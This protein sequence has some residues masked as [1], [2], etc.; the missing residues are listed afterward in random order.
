[1]Q[2]NA[3]CGVIISGGFVELLSNYMLIDPAWQSDHYSTLLRH[4][5]SMDMGSEPSDGGIY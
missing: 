4:P 1:M 2:G 5:L 3:R